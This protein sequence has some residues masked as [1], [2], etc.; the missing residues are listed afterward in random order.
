MEDIADVDYMHVQEFVK[1]LK[2]KKC[3][4][5]HNLYLKGDP[6]LLTDVFENFRKPRKLQKIVLELDYKIDLVL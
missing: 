3:G 5:Y 2:K 1:T 4:E 6:L